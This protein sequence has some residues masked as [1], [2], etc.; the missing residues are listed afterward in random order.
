M[1]R[2]DRVANP[3]GKHSGDEATAPAQESQ[4]DGSD[5]EPPKKKKKQLNAKQLEKKR[6]CNKRFRKE[7]G[8]SSKV[9]G[10]T[11]SNDSGA[12]SAALSPSTAPSDSAI[13]PVSTAGNAH[14]AH[15]SL[16]EH[17]HDPGCEHATLM[18]IT[19]RY[20][21]ATTI[22]LVHY[23]T[24]TMM[25]TTAKMT[26][27]RD[28]NL[29]DQPVVALHHCLPLAHDAPRLCQLVVRQCRPASVRSPRRPL[30]RS[31]FPMAMTE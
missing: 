31:Q 29:S 5:H 1:P 22:A 7:G 16:T 9:Q 12:A 25:A 17:I 24:M 30:S 6:L 13:T 11:A 27:C 3:S 4:H 20:S 8:L 28:Q 10:T 19:H 21:W 2:K 15:S 23:L 26:I 14:V 18:S